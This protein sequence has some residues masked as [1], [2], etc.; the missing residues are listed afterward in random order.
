MMEDKNNRKYKWKN[1]PACSDITSLGDILLGGVKGGDE[2][3]LGSKLY[4]VKNLTN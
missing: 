2:I 3:S 4:W 1:I